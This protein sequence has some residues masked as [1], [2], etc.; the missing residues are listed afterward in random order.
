ML[1]KRKILVVSFSMMALSSCTS[2][3]FGGYDAY[4]T[5][6][7][8]GSM[9][10]PEGYDSTVTVVDVPQKQAVVVPETYHVS[11]Y[12]SP[13]P[14]KDVD[15][16]WID[17]QNP[18]NYTIELADGDKPSVVAGA[19]SK[20][21]KN[22]R[23]AEIKY[24][25]N[26]KSYYKGLYGSYSNYDEAQQALNALPEDVKKGAGIKSWSNVQQTVNGGG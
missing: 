12:H 10:Y 14:P 9:L 8:Q 24:Q 13:A 25:H 20:T 2:D 16:N 21:P 4:Q 6:T 17:G 26:G 5:N 18:Q 22:E 3:Y 7:N 19:M 15:R 23:M 11:A 1:T